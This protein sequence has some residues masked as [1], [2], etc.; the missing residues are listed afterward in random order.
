MALMFPDGA[1][2]VF[3]E[4]S[5]LFS[6]AGGG[7]GGDFSRKGAQGFKVRVNSLRSESTSK[8]AHL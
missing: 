4:K 8:L 5:R 2:G 3:A 7:L 6:L 1:Q